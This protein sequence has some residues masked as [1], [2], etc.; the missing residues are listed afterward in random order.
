MLIFHFILTRQV[1]EDCKKHNKPIIVTKCLT[2]KSELAKPGTVSE[3]QG[4]GSKYLWG[5]AFLAWPLT[6]HG[7]VDLL[8]NPQAVHIV[9]KRNGKHGLVQWLRA[10]LQIWK[11]NRA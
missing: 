6:V 4:G 8:M 2:K 9:A 7:P 10:I 11:Q 5:S 1:T 3:F